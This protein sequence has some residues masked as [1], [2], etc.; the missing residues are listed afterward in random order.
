MVTSPGFF[1]LKKPTCF[2]NVCGH[3]KQLAT[4]STHTRTL[5]APLNPSV[6]DT[7]GNP[8]KTELT[9]FT[10]FMHQMKMDIDSKSSYLQH[11][12]RLISFH[13]LE[14]ACRPVLEQFCTV[15]N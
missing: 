11:T 10:W 3:E 14:L 12:L 4:T 5:F 6:K 7:N 2:K 13:P 9:N 15:A 1:F 8:V